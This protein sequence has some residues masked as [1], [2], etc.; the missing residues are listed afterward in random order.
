MASAFNSSTIPLRCNF[1]HM[2]KILALCI[3]IVSL[4]ANAQADISFDFS[5]ADSTIAILKKKS[6]TPA[7]V[8]AFVKTSGVQSIIKKIRSNDSIARIVIEKVITD[9]P[10]TGKEND[11]QYVFIKKNLAAMEAFVNEIKANQQVIKDSLQSFTKFL[12][13]DKKMNVTV[14]F[15]LGSYSSGF[16]FS[17][18]S[19]FYVGLH[20]Y[21]YDFKSIVNTCQ[22]EVFHNVQNL[23]RNDMP[24]MTKLEE[25]N[26]LPVLYAYYIARNFFTEGAAEYVADIDK[27]DPNAPNLKLQREH[28]VINQYR[29]EQNFYLAEKLIL[30]AYAAPEKS[31][32]GAIYSI[33][34][35]WNW[36]NPGYAMGKWMMASLVK[37]QGPGAVNK[38]LTAGPMIFLQ[39][40]MKL[41]KAEP[42][43]YSYNFSE[44]FEK[45]LADVIAKTL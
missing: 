37:A 19:K 30:D 34:F 35:D 36:N 13:K 25:K 2:N 5:N 10:V 11:F 27:T 16:T 1:K 33:L 18:A 6:V 4:S 20:Q 21:K 32:P 38:Y 9:K 43:K 45:M 14:S 41:A 28:A 15:L 31:D 12:G 42:A 40:Y 39:D 29:M 3:I 44:A 7:E 26:E 17:D 23:Y 8:S 22:H 24:M